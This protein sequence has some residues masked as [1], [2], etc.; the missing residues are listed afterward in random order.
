MW[1]SA[2][3]WANISKTR[4]AWYAT[5]HVLIPFGCDFNFQ[6]ALMKYKNMDLLIEYIN[7]HSEELGIQ[8]Q[9]STLTDYFNDVYN[10]QTLTNKFWGV[11][12]EDF[13]PYASD[14]ISYWAGYYTSRPDLKQLARES[15]AILQN[16]GF[17]SFLWKIFSF[18]NF[19]SQR[20]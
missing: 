15:M 5:P 17:F 2:L 18:C 1:N 9:Y 19:P 6:N 3:E 12:A 4:A 13:F 10:Y 14:N 16:A 11:R 20:N 7:Q 8:A